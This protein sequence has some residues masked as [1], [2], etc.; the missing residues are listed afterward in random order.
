MVK[1]RSYTQAIAISIFFMLISLAIFSI[2]L[3]YDKKN[4]LRFSPEIEDDLDKIVQFNNNQENPMISSLSN[5]PSVILEYPGKHD[6]T[7][8]II[9]VDNSATGNNDG[10]SWENA[11]PTL[12]AAL[13]DLS[14][15]AD[16]TIKI[17]EGN[18][19]YYE[20]YPNSYTYHIGSDDSG[21]LNHPNIIESKEGDNP[22]FYP[23]NINGFLLQGEY[24]IIR[25]LTFTGSN[26]NGNAFN[27]QDSNNIVFENNTI[28]NPQSNGLTLGW[29][30]ETTIRNNQIFQSL[31][32]IY[33]FASHNNIIEKNKVY[34]NG[35]V[36][37]VLSGSE[38][39]GYS[40]NNII[41]NNLVFENGY[42]GEGCYYEGELGGA[43]IR[44]EIGS[45]NNVIESNTVDSN[46][47]GFYQ[48]QEVNGRGILILQS[49]NNLL[50]NNIVTNNELTGIYL[51][52]GVG[53]QLIY[54]DV[55]N[56]PSNYYNISPGI[57]SISA[58]PKYIERLINYH[59]RIGSLTIDKGD[60]SSPYQ[61]EPRPNG[62]RINMGSYG[63]T[64][65][66]TIS[67]TKQID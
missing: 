6:I 8:R 14:D 45:D 64:K 4:N 25:G 3:D 57:G 18:E 61:N 46:K 65:E 13:E 50:K 36:G 10:S 47:K 1:K 29:T 21:I 53:T 38:S 55:W 41:K 59:V 20:E 19:V 32:G 2:K 23:V 26:G 24:I 49:M 44:I 9:Y 11:Y 62:N 60:P 52:D 17:A 58:D 22:V 34:K 27:I 56:N 28:S 48:G 66:A 39:A 43:G 12:Y 30:S 31:S 63:N 5:E 33:L 42:P 51:Y 35:C 54:S 16:T 7:N 40:T 15:E 67:S 37:V